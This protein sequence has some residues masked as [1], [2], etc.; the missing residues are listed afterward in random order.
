MNCCEFLCMSMGSYSSRFDFG[1]S[2]TCPRFL[3]S[4]LSMRPWKLLRQSRSPGRLT[5]LGMLFSPSGLLDHGVEIWS[6]HRQLSFEHVI[7]ISKHRFGTGCLGLQ[8]HLL[9]LT[10]ELLSWFVGIYWAWK[11]STVPQSLLPGKI[12]SHRCHV[13]VH[14]FWP[15]Q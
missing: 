13:L 6:I 5:G 7:T 1:Y 10:V 12:Q 14:M 15:V 2:E 9:W 8:L 3:M 11:S 4:L